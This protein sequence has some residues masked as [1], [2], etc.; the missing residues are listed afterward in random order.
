MARNL[1]VHLAV[2]DETDGPDGILRTS[3]CVSL[4]NCLTH[5]D[6]TSRKEGDLDEGLW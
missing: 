1:T 2:D 6:Q 5:G 3:L 4:G